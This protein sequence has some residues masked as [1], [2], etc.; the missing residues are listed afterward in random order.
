MRRNSS[1]K[2]DIAKIKKLK[3]LQAKATDKLNKI[4]EK[5]ASKP[6]KKK[7]AKAATKNKAKTTVK[8]GTLWKKVFGRKSQAEK[9]NQ[10]PKAKSKRPGKKAAGAH[11]S[12]EG[13][14]FR[15]FGRG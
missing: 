6:R 1:I 12:N 14:V 5:A 4:T 10:A 15:H 8:K 11:D 3:A 13:F 2:S 7:V 9:R